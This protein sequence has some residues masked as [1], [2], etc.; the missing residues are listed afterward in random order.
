MPDFFYLDATQAVQGPLSGNQLAAL[1]RSGKIGPATPVA[2]AGSAQWRPLAEFER[3]TDGLNPGAREFYVHQDG[4]T[5]GPFSALELERLQAQRAFGSQ[6]QVARGGGTGWV[7]LAAAAVGGALLGFLAAHFRASA[8]AA[9]R[10]QSFRY[11]DF[12]DGQSY[13]ATAVDLDGDGRW[14]AVGLDTNHDGAVDTVGLDLDGDGIVDAVGVDQDHDGDVD[15]VGIDSNHDGQ[16]DIAGA[17]TDGD[18]SIDLVEVDE[19]FD[20]QPDEVTSEPSVEETDS[21]SWLADSGGD[22]DFEA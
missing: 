9:P 17:D 22:F 1:A 5:R 19:D 2:A 10:K 16:I 12:G 14:D 3:G 13:P 4:Q 21:G 20:G 8:A 7:P 6:A 18:G 11:Y 15:L